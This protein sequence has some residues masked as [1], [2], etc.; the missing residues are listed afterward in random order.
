MIVEDQNVFP[1]NVVEIVT[2]RTK[3]LDTDLWVTKRPLRESDPN[4]VCGHLCGS[5]VA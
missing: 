1:N 2:I 3:L 4:S 5:M